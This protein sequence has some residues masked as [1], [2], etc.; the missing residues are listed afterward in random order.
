MADK[1]TTIT[2]RG[3]VYIPEE[4]QRKG[5]FKK[6]TRLK[7]YMMGKKVVLEP[8]KSALSLAGFLAKRTKK[9]LPENYRDLMEKNYEK[10]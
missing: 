4:F 5:Q 3:L 10:I 2:S 1:F 9:R 8:T 6:P 7:I